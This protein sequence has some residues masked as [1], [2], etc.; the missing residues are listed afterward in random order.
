MTEFQQ[1]LEKISKGDLGL[2]DSIGSMQLA[3]QAAVSQAFRTPEILRLFALAQ[4]S[5]LRDRLGVIER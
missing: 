4:P 2:V 3:I 5:Q 1:S